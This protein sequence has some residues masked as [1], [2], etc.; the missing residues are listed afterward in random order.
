MFDTYHNPLLRIAGPRCRYVVNKQ[1]NEGEWFLQYP[2]GYIRSFDGGVRVI[3][4]DVQMKAEDWI[5]RPPVV[6][7]DPNSQ[8]YKAIKIRSNIDREKCLHG[9]EYLLTIVGGEE[10]ARLYLGNKS[11]RDLMSVIRVGGEYILFPCKKEFQHHVWYIPS[12]VDAEEFDK[13]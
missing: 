13:T 6:S 1:I 2:T 5:V 12:V 7:I 9:P 10:Q 3:I 11:S 8:C 4:N